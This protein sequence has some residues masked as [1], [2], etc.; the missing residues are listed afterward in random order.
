MGTYQYLLSSGSN[1]T[2]GQS[3][4]W[5]GLLTSIIEN[6]SATNFDIEN[7]D[8]SLTEVDG[9]G[10]TFNSG[11]LT[12]GTITDAI[13]MRI[14][15]SHP[16]HIEQITGLNL[17]A[18]VFG[19]I[20]GISSTAAF[21]S[22]LIDTILTSYLPGTT[23]YYDGEA[24]GSNTLDLTVFGAIGNTITFGTLGASEEGSTAS[25]QG[26][27]LAVINNIQIIDA[28]AGDDEFDFAV[29]DNSSLP[30]DLTL[31]GGGGTNTIL[32]TNDQPSD[33]AT[34]DL[35]T[36]TLFS[37][38]KL[39]ITGG[40]PQNLIFFDASQ[41]GTGGIAQPL[42]IQN[43]N[44]ESDV[45]Y[46]YMSTATSFDASGFTFTDPA[47]AEVEINGS[48]S[49]SNL[50]IIG[51]PGAFSA[52]LGGSGNDVITAF[53][54]DTILGNAGFNTL[55]EGSADVT[56]VLGTT[57]ALGIQEFVANSGDNTISVANSDTD[58]VYLY[59]GSGND[60]MSSGSGGSYLF[61][62]GGANTLTG[63]GGT[64]V[65]IGGGGGSNIMN[66]GAGNN[67][68]YTTGSDT[69]HGA[70]TYNT[71]VLLTTDVNLSLG[72]S[73]VQLVI[74]NSGTN[75]VSMA[76]S[77]QF[78]YLY[79]GAGNDTLATGADGG[80]LIGEGG[81]NALYGGG[82]TNVFIGGG[83]GSNAMN[84][85]S[86][87]NVYYIGP[88]DSV[89]GAGTFNTLIELDTGVTETLGGP[90]RTDIQEVLANAGNNVLDASALGTQIYLYGGAN[91]DTLF[92]G[93][94][95]DFLYGGAGTNTFGF[96]PGWGM[97]T[98]MDWTS[99]TNNQ[100]D[101]TA[102]ASEG[103]HSMANL[104][105]SVVNG[106]DVVT[107]TLAGSNSITLY[108]FVGALTASNFKFA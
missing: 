73:D 103:L 86:G 80:Y 40:G 44:E 30:T 63:G 106:S 13:H 67:V 1:T 25:N 43:D 31:N 92:G 98:I 6:P 97:D 24:S 59:G 10:F 36:D 17:S 85:G 50:T 52:L 93:T 34:L 4:T 55:I 105:I 42:A 94:G 84:G 56:V 27:S 102:L 21:D 76:G 12:G 60:T 20:L 48:A 46:V 95:N 35:T 91:N 82:G 38:Q 8:G 77:N 78:D 61:G 100:I 9:S 104:S 54:G 89:S 15:L 33:P 37:I 28:S 62:E 58:F 47:A 5:A 51:S 75:S 74:L 88:N 90:G 49:S 72:S 41:F 68:Y 18:N 96:K 108:G 79:G 81:S 3:Y 87:S 69:I 29:N 45:I 64:N 83:G 26:N 2:D 66:G 99:G 71:D 107:S 57:N 7:S 32:M 14:V 22:L 101:L 39:D 16:V 53:A 23:Q 70:G 65:F 11:T 19:E